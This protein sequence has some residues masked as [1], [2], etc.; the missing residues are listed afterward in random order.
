MKNEDQMENR[1][2]RVGR[3]GIAKGGSE[4]I[5]K[6]GKQKHIKEKK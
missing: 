5:N 6:K 4:K 1:N 3:R 2:E